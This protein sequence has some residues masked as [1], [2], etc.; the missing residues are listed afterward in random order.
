MRRAVPVPVLLFVGML[1][2][3]G[4]RAE[5]AFK[6]YDPGTED[7][8]DYEKYGTFT[9]SG[10]PEFRY[11]V[12]DE[13]GLVL[14][15]GEAIDPCLSI[16]NNPEFR[17]AQA[18]GKLKGDW[19]KHVSTFNPQLDYFVWAGAPEDAGVRLLFVGKALEKGGQLM[20]ALKAYRAAMVLYPDAS[21]WSAGSEF[22]WDVATAAWNGIQNLLR[23][24]PELNVRLVGA[25]V[26]NRA[27]PNGLV[28]AV[29]P[30]RLER[31][32][33]PAPAVPPAEPTVE[34]AA[35]G[36]EPATETGVV[37]VAEAADTNAPAEGSETD[38]EQELPPADPNAVI[39]K[40]G[41]GTVQLVQYGS[42]DWDMMVN[43]EPYFIRGMNYA[44]TMVGVLPWEWN[45]LWSDA[46]TNGIVDSLEVWV[47]ANK[48][49]AQD[50][51]EPTTTDY[52]LMRDLG[53]NT[54]KFYITDPELP[55]FNYLLM[56][57]M[58]YQT[59]LR[60]VVGNFLG[61]YC[62]GS[63]ADWER[64]TD[65]TN[66][67]QK[68][69]MRAS[70]SNLVMKL[71]GEP[72]L[73]AW[74]LGNENNMELS[75]EVNATRTNGSKYPDTYAHFLNEVAEMIHDLDPNHPVGVGNLLTG[76]VEFYGKRAPALD[77][78]GINSYI[79]EDG[80]G[81]TWQK[82][83]QT[84]NRPVII[85]E[86]GCDSY[87]TAKGPDELA[88]A[89]YLLKNWEDI[90]Y[91]RAGRGGAGNSIGGFVFEWLDEWWKDT[92]NYFEDAPGHQATRPIFPMPFPD[93]F[94]Q[95]EWFGIIGQG[96][97]NASPFQRVPKKAYYELKTKWTEETELGK[98]AG[99]RET[100]QP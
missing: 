85:T 33:S 55:C 25:D 54:I 24:H 52:Q 93:G 57:R 35:E 88:Q 18:R 6:I 47:D 9:N 41:T 66:R 72:W 3:M 30:G 87:W 19:W 39:M 20:H 64:G 43:G 81:A 53:V 5:P 46:D 80:F 82:V 94:A 1:A 59:G 45:W 49:S 12:K 97:G 40:R 70:V 23:K 74:V 89:N 67:K 60:A 62:N 16:T 96:A 99:T 37:E 4:A 84:M 29:S 95:E 100:E 56:R 32:P 71:R 73:L 76:L 44:P 22:Q 78:I 21:C 2:A 61:A 42:G 8:V 63:G 34:P 86:F 7:L 50:A 83:K 11:V 51:E 79:G 98:E 31:I 28:I 10:T 92:F 48:N 65:Y 13:P 17:K 38:V 68:E 27:G 69:N 91:N 75:G 26:V 77:F 14:A 15:S 36:A 90:D 58:F